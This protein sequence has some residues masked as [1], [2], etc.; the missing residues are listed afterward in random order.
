MAL[1]RAGYRVLEARHGRDAL[2]VF[3]DTV[4]LVVVDMVLPY[5]GGAEMIA[6]LH[7]RR[8]SLKVLCISGSPTTELPGIPFLHKPFPREALLHAVRTLLDEAR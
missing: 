4:D 3:N 1:E 5:L 6:K 2:K 7:E 8:P